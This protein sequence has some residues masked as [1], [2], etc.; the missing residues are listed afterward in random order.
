MRTR[1]A[2]TGA[3]AATIALAAGC[4]GSSS[5]A[6]KEAPGQVMRAVIAHELYGQ[7]AFTY[8]LLVREQRRVVGAKLY[9][10]CSPG[11][12]A[13]PSN[14]TL[15]ILG[16]RDESFSVP[17]IGRT[18]TKAVDYRIDLHDG[19]DP[20]VSTGHLVA[21]DGHWRWTLSSK[22]F[23]SFSSGVCP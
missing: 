15:D 8:K 9:A 12:K 2:A 11:P 7:Q 19:A 23:N 18:K 1:V 5:A 21:E 22:S 3:V 17:A 14:F 10:S 4:G 16:V 6:P 20:I 13:Q